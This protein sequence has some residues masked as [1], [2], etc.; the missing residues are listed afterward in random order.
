MDAFEA[1]GPTTAEPLAVASGSAFVRL[2]TI[3]IVHFLRKAGPGSN[4]LL[5]SSYS[6]L[7]VRSAYFFLPRRFS[8]ITV[9]AAVEL[10][11]AQPSGAQIV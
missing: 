4:S 3:R 2:T 5:V 7:I 11:A 6:T 8:T 10:D 1:P 9:T